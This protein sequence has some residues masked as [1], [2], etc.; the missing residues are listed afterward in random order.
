[1]PKR[2]LPTTSTAFG[3]LIGT[4]PCESLHQPRH[5]PTTNTTWTTHN[6]THDANRSRNIAK[7]HNELCCFG[8]CLV[9]CAKKRKRRQREPPIHADDPE[10]MLR[11]SSINH[12]GENNKVR[13]IAAATRLITTPK[14]SPH[15]AVS[16]SNLSP[17]ARSQNKPW[18][19]DRRTF[20]SVPTR[21]LKKDIWKSLGFSFLG[22]ERRG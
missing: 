4:G 20:F 3:A 10:M 19:L 13:E 12:I 18:L 2:K 1:M 15:R 7:N 5:P 16:T 6:E 22:V 8:L 21:C 9:L 11:L 14:S 17:S